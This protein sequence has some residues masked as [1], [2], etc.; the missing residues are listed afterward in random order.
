[1]LVFTNGVFDWLHAGHVDCLTT[2]RAMGDRLIVGVNGD[3]S[4]R[5]LNK[6]A[7]RPINAAED[8]AHVLRALSV[9]S[10]VVVFEEDTPLE[11]ICRLRPDVF[12]KGDDYELANLSEVAMMKTWGGRT[13]IV[14]RTRGLSTTG[15]LAVRQRTTVTRA[16]VRT[17]NDRIITKSWR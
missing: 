9:V 17:A 14:K 6:G 7:N 10:E 13:V 11:L 2:A 3:A 12:V 4:A 16:T 15:L 1:M 8:R 5:R